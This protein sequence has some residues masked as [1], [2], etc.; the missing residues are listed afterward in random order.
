MFLCL[1]PILDRDVPINI[2]YG[3][4]STPM[5]LFPD[6]AK[7]PRVFL[8]FPESNYT[9]SKRCYSLRCPNV[10]EINTSLI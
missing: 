3:S 9:Y 4:L 10:P 1:L 7:D 2:H 6:L 5:D 8:P